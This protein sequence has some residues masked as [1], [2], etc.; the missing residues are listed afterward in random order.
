MKLLQCIVPILNDDDG[1]VPMACG[2]G[3]LVAIDEEHFLLSAAHV[4]DKTAK[5]T[6]LIPTLSELKA[7][8]GPMVCTVP[9]DGDRDL[10]WLDVGYVRL[11]AAEAQQLSPQFEFLP[12]GLIDVNDIAT[13]QSHY[14]FSGYPGS[15]VQRRYRSNV[16]DGQQHSY[17]GRNASYCTYWQAGTNFIANIVVTFDAKRAIDQQGRTVRP[18]DRHGMSGGGVW[19]LSGSPILR[20]VP[21]LR[22]CGVITEHPKQNNCLVGTRLFVLLEMIRKDLPHLSP[23]IPKST[24]LTTTATWRQQSSEFPNQYAPLRTKRHNRF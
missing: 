6:L 7:I 10:D 12:V 2:S 14:V 24:V 11:T 23:M 17:T 3:V 20:K 21:R 19:V 13:S 8:R 22:L 16:L 1:H 18:K 15:A 4:L 9:P 5:H